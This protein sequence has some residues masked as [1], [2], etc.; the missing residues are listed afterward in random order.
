MPGTAEA[1]QTFTLSLPPLPFSFPLTFPGS[2]LLYLSFFV[3]IF[4]L[5][6]PFL[7]TSFQRLCRAPVPLPG[8]RTAL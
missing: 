7:E 8:D 1:L 6:T 3:F 5:S 2:F 4:S